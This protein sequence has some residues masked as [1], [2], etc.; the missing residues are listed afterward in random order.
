VKVNINKT[1]IFVSAALLAL[2]LATGTAIAEGPCRTVRSNLENIG[3]SIEDPSQCNGYDF[4]QSVDIRG[5]LNGTWWIFG[6][7]SGIEVL[8][9][10]T[11]LAFYLDGVFSDQHGELL[12]VDREILNL[13]A[14]DGLGFNVAVVGGT[15]RY[16]GASG[17]MTGYATFFPVGGK[18]FGEVCWDGD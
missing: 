1:V 13:L 5:T 10:G 12:L 4:C 2:T 7:N 11:A 3:E 16:E 18:I 6:N 8:A 14:E 15:G 9:E 17:W